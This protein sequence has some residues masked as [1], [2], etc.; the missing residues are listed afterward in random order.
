MIIF[1]NPKSIYDKYEQEINKNIL[2]VLQDGR[3]IK[4]KELDNFHSWKNPNTIPNPDSRDWK[5]R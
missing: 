2:K 3:Y 4:S 5:R 1:N